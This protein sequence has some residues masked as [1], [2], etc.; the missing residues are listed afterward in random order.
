V[1]PEDIHS[2]SVLKNESATSI[3][4]EQGKN[5]V[6]LITTK[7]HAEETGEKEE[8]IKV[9][10]ALKQEKIISEAGKKGEKSPLLIVDGKEYD[11]SHLEKI[12]PENIESMTVLKDKS[13]TDIYGEKGKNGVIIITMKRI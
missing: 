7:R 1:K 11:N 6:I 4:G 2:I 13:S 3:Y 12:K 8:Y 5:G 9:K 10:D